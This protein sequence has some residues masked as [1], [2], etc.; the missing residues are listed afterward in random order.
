MNASHQ[1]RLTPL[2]A[3]PLRE[4]YSRV[5]AYIAVAA[6]IA[7]GTYVQHF[8]YD[9]LWMVPYALLYPHLAHHLQVI[10]DN[11]EFKKNYVKEAEK[12]SK[13]E[14]L[15]S[16]FIG[17]QDKINTLLTKVYRTWPFYDIPTEK[18]YENQE[19]IRNALFP[20][21]DEIVAYYT[22]KD[23]DLVNLNLR[24]QQYF[25]VEVSFLSWRDSIFFY[26]EKQLIIDSKEK[27]AVNEVKLYGFKIPSGVVWNDS[28]IQELKIH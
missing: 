8:G 1:T 24:N 4:Y 14:F 10:Y 17:K 25:P 3:P 19:Y 7:A 15:D 2:P 5:L 27:V 12:I 23:N 28:M 13:P 9:I 22:E 16:L 21:I 26:P 6:T 20:N 18:L 11:L